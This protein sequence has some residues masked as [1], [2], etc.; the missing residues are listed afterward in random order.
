MFAGMKKVPKIITKV[1]HID[2]DGIIDLAHID[3]V[4]TPHRIAASSIVKY[5]RAMENSSESS[6]EAIYKFDDDNFEMLE[7]NI[8]S[9]FRGINIKIKDL[10]L[11]E[12]I[13]LVAILRGRHIIL[14]NGNE[15][16]KPKDT[17]VIIDGSNQ[18][19]EINDILV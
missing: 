8:K 12:N 14:P 2:L 5:V 4:I 10:E 7:F 11:K 3:T 19:K 15:E 18:V 16:I 1:S 17:I 6:C 9:D 13:L